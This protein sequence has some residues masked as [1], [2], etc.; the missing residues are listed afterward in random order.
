METITYPES[1]TEYDLTGIITIEVDR[2]IDF[3]MLGSQHSGNVIGYIV[4][5]EG[6][7]YFRPEDE[8]RSYGGH[9][10]YEGCFVDIMIEIACNSS[11]AHEFAILATRKQMELTF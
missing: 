5:D 4:E 2:N 10:V 8:N 3:I 11:L 6:M 9:A 1:K 7:F